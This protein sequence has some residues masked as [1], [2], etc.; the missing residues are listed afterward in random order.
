MRHQC[1]PGSDHRRLFVRNSKIDLSPSHFIVNYWD[2]NG[3]CFFFFGRLVWITYVYMLY[4]FNYR[5]WLRPIIHI[6]GPGLP[7]GPYYNNFMT[8]IPWVSTIPWVSWD[9]TEI[10]VRYVPTPLTGTVCKIPT[11]DVPVTNPSHY[12]YCIA[13][14]NTRIIAASVKW[15][16]H[17]EWGPSGKVGHQWPWLFSRS[18][19]QKNLTPHTQPEPGL[20]RGQSIIDPIVRCNSIL[21][22]LCMVTN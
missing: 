4:Y 7:G 6:G 2:H 1:Y 9:T 14:R 12:E 8:N 18:L 10:W 5:V 17:M 3:L 21:D 20:P 16:G 19:H 11:C 22:K 13:C 15:S